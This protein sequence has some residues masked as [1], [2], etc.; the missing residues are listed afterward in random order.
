M[1]RNLFLATICLA[2]ATSA[3]DVP[4]A[5]VLVEL[6]TSEGCSSC[7]PADRHL[8]QLD[9]YS[10]VLSEHVDYWNQLG[11]KDRFSSPEYTQR[12]ETYAK[13]FGLDSPY[14]PQMVVDGA[15]QF[16][17]GDTRR[18]AVEIDKAANRPKASIVLERIGKGVRVDVEDVPHDADIWLALA[19]ETDVSRVAAGENKGRTLAHVAVVRS[20][21]KLGYVKRGG[22]FSRH[23]DLP[24][25]AGGQRVVVFLQEAGQ[26][27]VWGAAMLSAPEI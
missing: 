8:Q 17:G 13:E 22:T 9:R 23:I 16:T 2:F 19:D 1:F 14:T 12:Q 7:P 11:W 21:R 24:D 26:A 15:A 25:S 5:P 4:R 18:A 6:F 10:I 20:L 27:R 3:A